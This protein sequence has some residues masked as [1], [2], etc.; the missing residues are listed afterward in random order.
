VC[1]VNN[2]AKVRYGQ[3][4][5]TIRFI[6]IDRHGRPV[7]VT[8]ATFAIVDVDQGDDSADRTIAS[9][10]ASLAA[11]DTP[12]SAAGGAGEP[13]PRRLTLTSAVGVTVGRQ[14]LVATAAGR[15]LVTVDDVTGSVVTLKHTPAIAFPSGATFQAIELE[16]S[17]PLSEANDP[18]AIEQ[19]RDYQCTWSYSLQGESWVTPQMVWLMRYSGEAWITEEDVLLAWPTMTSRIRGRVSIHD[20][21]TVATQDLIAELESADVRA[22]YYRTALP[23]HVAIRNRAIEYCLRWC[24]GEEDIAAAELYQSRY[25]K[26][27]GN[28]ITGKPGTAQRMDAHSDTQQPARIDGIFNKP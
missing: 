5:Q 14:Y 23:G 13:D 15:A 3:G 22:E 2:V 19:Q 1:G 24:G 25:E 26:L 28:F 27:V 17:F 7:R 8:S 20:A 10:S 16:A 18:D 11:V 4:A 6:P 9:G 21:I 12:L